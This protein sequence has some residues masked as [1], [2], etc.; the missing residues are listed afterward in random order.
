MV[1]ESELRVDRSSNKISF[2]GAKTKISDDDKNAIE[3][4]VRLKE[5]NG[6]TVTGI[7]LGKSDAKKSVKEALAMGC[8]RARLLMDPSFEEG[9]AIRTAYVLSQTI[10]KIGKYD[11]VITAT[12]TTDVYSGIVGPALAEFLAIPQVTFVS[13]V[14]LSGNKATLERLLEE[15]VETVECELPILITVVREINQP[16]FPTLIQIMS[17][18]KKEIL[19]WKATDITVDPSSVGKVGSLTEVVSIQ[20]PK[21]ARK[22]IVF[23][24]SPEETSQKLADALLK[25]GVVK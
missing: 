12:G 7:C 16:R 5:K 19:E 8:D 11:I 22:R 4:A 25:E 9:D 21:S 18:G 14:S 10:K 13:K 1:D 23:E 15:G 2:E 24:G 20:V 6:G 3:E 17:A